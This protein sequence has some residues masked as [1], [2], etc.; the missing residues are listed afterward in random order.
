MAE[1]R[2]YNLDAKTRTNTA[3]M[4]PE[5]P[6]E[7]TIAHLMATLTDLAERHKDDTVLVQAVEHVGSAII[8]LLNGEVGRLDQ[9]IVDTKVRAVVEYAG[10]DHDSL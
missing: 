5:T 4:V 7:K 6:E 10:G 1:Q 9:G 2:N 8:V 3:L